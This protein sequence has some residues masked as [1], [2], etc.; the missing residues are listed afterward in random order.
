MSGA[1]LDAR[2]A[3]LRLFEI[4][5]AFSSGLDATS[6]GLRHFKSTRLMGQALRLAQLI[7][8]MDVIE[9]PDRLE[10]IAAGQ[11]HIDPMQF[12]SVLVA[13][14]EADLISRHKGKIYEKVRLIDFGENYERVGNVWMRKD[15]DACEIL[16][17]AALDE[18]VETP[19]HTA[20]LAA[21]SGVGKPERNLVMEVTKNA[22]LIEPIDVGTG[23]PVLFAPM[24]W[25]VNPERF[26]KVLR[27]MKTANVA[28][29]VR[30]VK[31]RPAGA[32]LDLMGLSE[33]E[34]ALANRAVTVG[35]LPTVP[36]NSAGG[37]KAFTFVPYSGAL[38]TN[39]TEREILDR[40]RAIVACVRY[41]ERHAV[42]SKIL[43]PIALL[44]VLLD[45][46][47]DHALGWHSEVKN[48]YAPLVKRGVGRIE[49]QGTRYQF[50][51]IDSDEN[52]RAVRLAI[53]LIKHGQIIEERVS[54]DSAHHAVLLAPGSIGSEFDGI[55]LAHNQ[56]KAT[57]DELEE[58]VE[59]AR[60]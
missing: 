35:L 59:S 57:D 53:E 52:K 18:L 39:V 21:F 5:S 48:Q 6:P 36:V 16:I 2:R 45:A 51:L 10:A 44:N 4:E 23:D 47:R 54:L 9:S 19:K 24:L 58:L 43:Y 56:Q 32:E 34:R 13:L 3:G 42:A 46:G 60:S 55:R 38:I 26:E 27:E 22:H 50:R 29:V 28:T 49:K 31:K 1:T 15:R 11:L 7:R 41:G 8:G 40:A 37:E 17:V 12:E 33:V 20:E 30:A 25:D 14:E